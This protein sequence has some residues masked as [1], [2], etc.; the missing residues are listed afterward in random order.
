MKICC[1]SSIYVNYSLEETIQ[2]LSA[3]GIQGLEISALSES[4]TFGPGMVDDARIE[5]VA[6]KA[7][8]AGM[9]IASYDCEVLPLYGRNMANPSAQVRKSVTEYIVESTDIARALG[10][11]YLVLVAGR[12]QFGTARKTAWK[13]LVEMLKTCVE[14]AEKRGVALLIEHTTMFE[15]NVVVTLHDLL[16]LL[17]AVKSD[18]LLPLVDTGHVA[19]NGESMV[20]YVRS[21][22]GRIRHIH[23]DDNN[24]RT[25]EHLPPGMGTINFEP[26]FRALKGI[27]YEGYLSIEPSFAFSA[28]PDSAVV[29]GLNTVKR[30]LSSL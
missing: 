6:A 3:L 11:P 30:L 10:A 29:A 18:H 28:D 27:G 8:R 5:A 4:V 26:L 15:G 2:R 1:H 13:W 12:A 22:G 14:H 21:L 17:D 7:R 25:N 19:V 20:D 16:E 9:E 23:I 24:G